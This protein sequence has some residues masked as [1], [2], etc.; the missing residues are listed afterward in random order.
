MAINTT[1]NIAARLGV[2]QRRIQFIVKLLALTSVDRIGKTQIYSEA[3]VRRIAERVRTEA[4]GDVLAVGST[5]NEL[6]K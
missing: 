2:S 4:A 1:A 5:I 3:D 6:L